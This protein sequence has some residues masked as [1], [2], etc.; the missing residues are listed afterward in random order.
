MFDAVQIMTFWRTT[1][2]RY[3]NAAFKNYIS[4]AWVPKYIIIIIDL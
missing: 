4:F 2:F 1:A 3:S